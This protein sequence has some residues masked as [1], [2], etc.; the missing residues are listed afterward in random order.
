MLALILTEVI[1]FGSILVEGCHPYAEDL[2]KTLKIN[3]LT[4]QGVK[5]CRRCKVKISFF[6]GKKE[7]LDVSLIEMEAVQTLFISSFP[8]VPVLDYIKD[9]N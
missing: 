9:V 7:L 2:W 3:K 8:G 6:L 1:S 4:F 5:L